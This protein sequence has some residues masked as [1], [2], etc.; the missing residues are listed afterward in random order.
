M[1]YK[2]IE[3]SRE[4]RLWIGQIF[5]PAITLAATTMAIPEVRQAVSMKAQNIKQSIELKMK[6]K[7][8]ER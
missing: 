2:Q 8:W 3:A 4:A 7:K 5:V 6:K 1:T